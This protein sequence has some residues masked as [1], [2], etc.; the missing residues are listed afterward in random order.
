MPEDKKQRLPMNYMT[1]EFIRQQT[2]NLNKQEK[3][4]A[5]NDATNGSASGTNLGRTRRATEDQHSERGKEFVDDE[6]PINGSRVPR[7]ET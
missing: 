1:D 2:N 4:N 5:T 3:K 7:K 6:G